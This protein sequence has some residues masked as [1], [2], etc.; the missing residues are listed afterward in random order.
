MNVLCHEVKFENKI[1]ILLSLIMCHD[2]CFMNEGNG[3]QMINKNI[4]MH[5]LKAQTRP[6]YDKHCLQCKLQGTFL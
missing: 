3:K 4:Q 6:K 2:L 5:Y 1:C